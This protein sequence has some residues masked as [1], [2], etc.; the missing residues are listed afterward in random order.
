MGPWLRTRDWALVHMYAD[1]IGCLQK[2]FLFLASLLTPIY[3]Y[4]PVLTLASL[5][6]TRGHKHIICVQDLFLPCASLPF[7]C[8]NF[9]VTLF[10]CREV[11]HVFVFYSKS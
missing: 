2:V 4:C 7:G 5:A 8:D 9:S 11:F 6:A 1:S 10:P 3:Y